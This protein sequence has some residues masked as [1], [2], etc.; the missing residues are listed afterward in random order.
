[1]HSRKHAH[2]SIFDVVTRLSLETVGLCQDGRTPVFFAG[3]PSD[4][5]PIALTTHDHFGALLPDP[6]SSAT[7][8]RFVS[9]GR[10]SFGIFDAFSCELEVQW[11]EPLASSI[12]RGDAIF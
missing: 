4:M 7:L 5:V 9:Q 8:P 6:T 2:L 10:L 11:I 3:D 1:M 12:Q